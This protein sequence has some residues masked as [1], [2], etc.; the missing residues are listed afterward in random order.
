MSR[1]PVSVN[2][3][4]MVIEA[5]RRGCLSEVLTIAACIEAGGLRDRS[6][7]WR[8]LT[9]E[10]TSDLL[11][12]LDCYNAASALKGGQAM[13]DAG[14]FAKAVFRAR[15]IRGHLV[16]AIE[17]KPRPGDDHADR[18]QLLKA[19]VAGMV[20]HLY[21]NDGYGGLRNGGGQREL[22]RESVVA[23]NAPW[24]TGVPF[25]LAVA[26][27]RGGTFTIH[28][29]TNATA[30]D[31]AWLIEVA[32]QL[33]ATAIRNYRYDRGRGAVV[34]DEVTIFNGQE[35][36]IKAVEAPSGV[37]ATE[38]LVQA[39]A[40][41][42]TGHS[43]EAHNAAVRATLN[44]LC[45]RSEGKVQPL[46]DQQLRAY[47]VE[48]ISGCKSLAEIA[49]LE[50]SL[51]LDDYAPAEIREEID[52]QA[53]PTIEVLG[54][55]LPVTYQTGYA[56]K[57]TLPREL[58]DAG[59]WKEL[60]DEGVLLP[61]GRAVTLEVVFGSW[62]N[63]T[64]QTVLLL[65][66]G[67]RE[68]LNQTQWSSWTDRPEIALP[69]VT[70]ESA[71]ISPITEVAYGTDVLTGQPLMAFGTV[72]YNT[73]HYYSYG[74]Y[75]RASWFQTQA[76]AETVRAQAVAKI[77]EIKVAVIAQQQLAEAK[78]RAEAVRRQASGLYNEHYRNLTADLRSR[79]SSYYVPSST[80][81]AVIEAWI[82]TVEAL[83]AEAQ[84][85]LADQQRVREQAEAERIEREAAV[86]RKLAKLT[87]GAEK[88][89]AEA[90]Q[91]LDQSGDD[92]SDAVYNRVL[93]VAD[94]QRLS[95]D[96]D[97]LGA[98]IAEATAALAAAKQELTKPS[99]G[100]A[101]SSADLAALA[102]RFK[103]H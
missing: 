8:A 83:V 101:V 39:L 36:E 10:R 51:N 58:V 90:V 15:E 45:A 84:A 80:D 25:D 55:L 40:Y 31:P 56:P 46:S 24:I 102:E 94:S 33:V 6:G 29:V 70:E 91:V 61:G 38:A 4:R 32:P 42:Y 2:L 73:N 23:R 35:T 81:P 18:K 27:R 71:E 30:V 17:T 12:E 9:D 74:P 68:Y 65:K 22:A 95:G 103:K 41:G 62:N 21:R 16:R 100:G 69:V 88:L 67:V 52:R 37:E 7:T 43:A 63:A 49:E 13:R 50:L 82:A 44:S 60:P 97:S 48:K 96:P 79:L 20:D 1:L 78:V 92:L 19:C 89:R 75:F 53:P 59:T 26:S 93:A 3:A 86:A 98:W 77:D 28:L 87:S 11:A 64:Y 47:Y 34:V 76:E 85:I 54:Q 99:S 72:A 14:L 57:V 5:E 66:A